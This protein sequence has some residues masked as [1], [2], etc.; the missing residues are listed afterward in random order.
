M[1]DSVLLSK[2]SASNY[3]TVTQGFS[4]HLV[5]PSEQSVVFYSNRPYLAPEAFNRHAYEHGNY[6]E[7]ILCRIKDCPKEPARKNWFCCSIEHSKLFWKE[8]GS[9]FW[10]SIRHDVFVRDNWKCAFCDKPIGW[11]YHGT[12]ECD[13]IIPV[14]FVELKFPHMPM[15]ERI[16][17]FIYNKE[18]LRPLCPVH[19]KTVTAEFA[20]L[21]RKKNRDVMLGKYEDL[22]AFMVEPKV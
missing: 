19:H 3:P 2:L 4:P 6:K 17:R 7:K 18:N 8:Y 14:A 1:I 20:F 22:T 16:H 5:I 13:H 21:R 10:S 15:I 12:L 9:Y 11:S